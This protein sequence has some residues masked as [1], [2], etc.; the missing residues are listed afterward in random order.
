[1]NVV[2]MGSNIGFGAA[3]NRA[4]AASEAEFLV[5]LNDDV[6]PKHGFLQ[7]LVAPLQAGAEVVAGVLIQ[8]ER[9]DRIETAGI[10]I[11]AGLGPY[12]YLHNEPVSRLDKPV[13]PPLGPCGGAAAYLRAAFVAVG[14]FDEGFFAYGEDVDL[15][16]RLRAAGARCALAREARAFHSGS[17]TL[18]Y[19]SLEKAKLV[20][21]S[22]G[23]L[24]RKY[25]VLR[26]PRAA[27]RAIPSELVASLILAYRHRSL[28]PGL[29]R[30]RGWKACDVALPPPRVDDVTVGFLDGLR[31]RYARSKRLGLD[32]SEA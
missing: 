27:I 8:D 14:G 11:D 32:G 6:M 25:G 21:F 13:P 20:G 22:R 15:A 1:V 19:Q 18:G 7:T 31:R 10:E 2:E 4:V 9:R 12:D 29:A 30:V 17:A 26:R 3:V 5:V 28:E 16:I 24:I 23:Y